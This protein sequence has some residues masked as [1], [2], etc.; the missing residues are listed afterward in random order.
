[1]PFCCV[2]NLFTAPSMFHAKSLYFLV[3]NVLQDAVLFQTAI[4]AEPVSSL[5]AIYPLDQ[6]EFVR[7][8]PTCLC[9]VFTMSALNSNNTFDGLDEPVRPTPG[10]RKR[11]LD[12]E[13]HK[14]QQK[15]RFSGGALIPT[16]GCQCN[17]C[18][19]Q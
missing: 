19:Y 5:N 15:R 1:M 7:C 8:N 10:G 16:V 3:S 17:R 12:K 2:L 4:S 11:R 6:S 9:S 18:V 14:K 13:N